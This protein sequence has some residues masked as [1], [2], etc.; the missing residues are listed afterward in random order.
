MNK[1]GIYGIKNI[2][3]GKWYIGQTTDL[4]K[5]KI[6][7]FSLLRHKKHFNTHLQFA[8]HKYGETVFE[9][10]ILEEIEEGL[11]DVQERLWIVHYKSNQSDF[12]YNQETGGNF[13]K[14][15]SE[16]TRKKMSLASI[17][18]CLS[19]DAKLSISIK[20]KGKKR[21]EESKLKMSLAGRGRI[22]SEEWKQNI[23]RALPKGDNHW[24]YGKP[25]SEETRNK[26]SQSK[27]GQYPS[28]ETLKK[29]SLAR[30][31][32]PWSEN[33]R[34]AQ[35]LLMQQR[36]QPSEEFLQTSDSIIATEELARDLHLSKPISEET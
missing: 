23:S 2:V 9:F 7:H 3:N 33:R 11:L 26:I 1:C 31:G 25:L 22:L 12:G 20:N 28:K 35:N 17:G 24:T 4:N 34:N 10:R 32:K 5:R 14:H 29:Q 8:F 21:S 36:V 6:G 15:L 16:E 30:K 18:H 27:K 19:E 13:Q